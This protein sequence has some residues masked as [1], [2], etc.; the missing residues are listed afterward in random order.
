MHRISPHWLDS[1]STISLIHGGFSYLI[2]TEGLSSP[3]DLMTD[4]TEGDRQSINDCQ[5]M[6]QWVSGLDKLI[7][8]FTAALHLLIYTLIH[9]IYKFKTTLL[10]TFC[11]KKR[12]KFLF[13]L[14]VQKSAANH[15]Q[16]LH[17]PFFTNKDHPIGKLNV[18]FIKNKEQGKACKNHG[19]ETQGAEL[20]RSLLCCQ[21]NRLQD[22]AGIADSSARNK[23]PERRMQCVKFEP[24]IWPC[25]N[26]G[27]NGNDINFGHTGGNADMRTQVCV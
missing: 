5:L 13:G 2:L 11:V 15:I 9:N 24:E 1:F 25:S 20:R 6:V 12:Q 14:H 26:R 10:S 4:W 18:W 19:V 16:T 8:L 3:N 27:D 7:F 23:N 22:P 17:L 21:S